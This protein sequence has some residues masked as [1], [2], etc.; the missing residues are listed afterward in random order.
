MR[1]RD[2]WHVEAWLRKVHAD[3]VMARVAMTLDEPLYDQACFHAQQAGEK[4]LKALLVALEQPV[5][6]THD[7]TRLLELVEVMLGPQEHLREPTAVLSLFAVG[8][9][10]PMANET[11][12]DRAE[13]EETLTHMDHVLAF[14]ESQFRVGGGK[15]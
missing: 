14:V 2:D 6:K 9:R 15:P 8:P 4:A 5:P 12:V 1:R 10:Y 13:A 3:T 11:Q 7:V